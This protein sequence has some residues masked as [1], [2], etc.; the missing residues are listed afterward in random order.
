MPTINSKAM[1]D[2]LI[3]NNGVYQDDPPVQSIVEY[4]NAWGKIAYG[5]NYSSRDD[6]TET[7]FVRN[8][9]TIFTR[10]ES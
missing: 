2:E 10:K 7:Q 6:Y 5:L 3:A 1:V 4:T 8:P 9:K